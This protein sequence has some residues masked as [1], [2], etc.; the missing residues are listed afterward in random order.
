MQ[1]AIERLQKAMDALRRKA[2]KSQLKQAVEWAESIDT[3]GY[4]RESVEAF[5]KALEQAKALLEDA[6]LSEDDQARIDA[7]VQALKDA[8]Q[9]LKKTDS[10]NN[11]DN[12]NH[13]GNSGQNTGGTQSGKPK[14]GDTTSVA[15][16]ILIGAAAALLF[17]ATA[18]SGYRKKRKGV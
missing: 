12:G 2:D 10:S 3:S 11:N 5:Q 16:W 18:A 1:A 17:A 4:T 8:I 9:N 7:A 14:T 15:T 6:D 13:N